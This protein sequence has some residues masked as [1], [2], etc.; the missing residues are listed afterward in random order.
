MTGIPILPPDGAAWSI[1]SEPANG[2]VDLVVTFPLAGEMKTLRV[3]AD[4]DA[5]RAFAQGVLA[6]AGDAG[7]RTSPHAKI[8]EA[9]R[10]R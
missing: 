8:L 3:Y 6:S 1:A 5:A 9:A 4:R 2:G 7:E 10:G